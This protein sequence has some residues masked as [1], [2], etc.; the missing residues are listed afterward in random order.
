MLS[1][2]LVCRCRYIDMILENVAW[3]GHKW[4]TDT[5]TG[6]PT[7][8]S[9][10]FQEL[11]DMAVELIKRGKVRSLALSPLPLIFSYK[12][13]KSLCGAGVRLPPDAAGD[14]GE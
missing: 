6:G 4:K 13:E 3:L 11:Y 12:S 2:V 1:K 14:Q 10:Y 9:D 8:S 7:Y 5:V